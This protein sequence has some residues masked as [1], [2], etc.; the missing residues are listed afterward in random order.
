[1]STHWGTISRLAEAAAVFTI[2]GAL[3]AFAIDVRDPDGGAHAVAAP[4]DA[5]SAPP[6]AD[7]AEGGPPRIEQQNGI[8]YVSGGVGRDEANAMDSMAGRFTL[9]LTM[10]VPGGEF[11]NPTT[12]RIEDQRGATVLDIRPNGP[13]LLAALPPGEYVIRAT[14]EGQSQ[15]RKASIPAHGQEQVTMSWPAAAHD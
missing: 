13:V 3:G 6:P 1:M 9:K 8:A 4:R 14:A 5:G 11:T 12:L 7:G 15:S 10:S 2:A